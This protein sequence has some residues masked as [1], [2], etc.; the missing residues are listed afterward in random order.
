[1]SATRQLVVFLIDEWRFALDL[2][3]VER[4]VRAAEVTPL[5]DSPEVILGV[6][7]VEGRVVP[8]FNIRKRLGM[9]ERE[10]ELSD[11]MIIAHA[12]SGSVALVVDEVTGLIEC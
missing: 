10:M 7:K 11:Q 5:P 1:M 12:S 4:V 2:P 3:I 6:L 9:P 8:V